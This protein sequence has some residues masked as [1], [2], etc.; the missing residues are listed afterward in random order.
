[1]AQKAEKMLLKIINEW[2]CDAFY[3]SLQLFPKVWILELSIKV[4][5][6]PGSVSSSLFESSFWIC[7]SC[8]KLTIL[9]D[10]QPVNRTVI[11]SATLSQERA[12]IP[13][14]SSREIALV[15]MRAIGSHF[16]I[17][18]LPAVISGISILGLYCDG[19]QLGKNL[20]H[21]SVCQ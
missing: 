19:I 5:R 8:C 12:L 16:I 20:W 2:L 3:K 18:P 1:M 17:F 14:F 6:I 11:I 4:F 13:A 10:I 9:P 21:N 7:V 15:Q